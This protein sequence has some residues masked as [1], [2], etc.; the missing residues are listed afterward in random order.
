MKKKQFKM[1]L[2]GL[3]FWGAF[4]ILG[5][6]SMEIG[7]KEKLGIP[8]RDQMVKEVTRARDAQNQAKEQFASA[9]EQFTTVLNVDGGD[10]EKKYKTLNREYEQSKS[11]AEAV[12]ERIERV[13]EVSVALFKEWEKELDQYSSAQLRNA[14]RRQ[15]EQTRRSYDRLIGAMER[16][17]DKID[18][19]LSAF[20]DQVLFLKHNLNARAIASLQGQLSSIESDIAVLVRDMETSIA[21]ADS[22]IKQM[23]G[24]TEIH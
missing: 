3:L 2:I 19:V 4:A 20:K 23:T 11:R 17:R 22:F 24:E 9:L 18:P 1:P 15:L 16:A 14:S 5:C 13:K 21:E 6:R 8:K 7:L 12:S 10:L